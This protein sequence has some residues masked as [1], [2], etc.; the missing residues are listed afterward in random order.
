MHGACAALL[1]GSNADG[2]SPVCAG[3]GG[4]HAWHEAE[5]RHPSTLP[6]GMPAVVAERTG[7][8][9]I[10]DF[11]SR[12]LLRDEKK[13]G[14]DLK[15]IR[16]K[17]NPNWIPV[18]L[19]KPTDFR[20]TTK[21]PNF[22]L[23]DDQ[24]KAISAYLWQTALTDKLPTAPKGDATRGK[25]LFETRGCLGCHSIGEGSEMQGGDFA[26]NLT[27]VGEKVNYD[28]LFRWIKNPRVRTRP[29]CPYEKKDIGPEDYAKHNLPYQIDFE[30]STCPTTATNC[31]SSR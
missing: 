25:E 11:R 3:V 15:E 13:I 24:I 17:L 26:A 8:T 7:L 14:P 2:G 10:S 19:H 6:L 21:M 30:H 16:A 20:P 23:N 5:G 12:D 28:Y 4:H 27:R 18:W 22:R 29:Y 9:V 31:R 1:Q